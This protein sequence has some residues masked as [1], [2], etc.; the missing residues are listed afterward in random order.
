MLSPSRLGRPGICFVLGLGLS[1]CQL[2]DYTPPA[3]GGGGSGGQGGDA[4]Y[5]SVTELALNESLALLDDTS[6]GTDQVNTS[7][8]VGEC[9]A[10]ERPGKE[11]VFPVVPSA[12]GTLRATLHAD[13]M[14][15]WLHT[16]S[17]CPGDDGETLACAFGLGPD[18]PDVNQI[19]VEA[20]KTYFVI[21]DA[22]TGNTGTFALELMLQ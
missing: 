16:R 12:S 14:Y 5:D 8:A 10:G 20:D 22:W 2:D 7:P 18:E 15:H 4:C 21:V 3:A 19:D 17:A 9:L 6:R 13:Y 1:S 11:L